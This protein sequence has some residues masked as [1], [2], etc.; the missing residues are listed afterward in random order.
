M[1]KILFILPLALLFSCQKEPSSDTKIVETVSISDDFEENFDAPHEEKH[2][3]P[4]VVQ[5]P[6]HP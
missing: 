1:Q 4:K 3:R 5:L 2:S 6:A